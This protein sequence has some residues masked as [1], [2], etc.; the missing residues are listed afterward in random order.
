MRIISICDSTILAFS[1]AHP[2]Q[3]WAGFLA[4]PHAGHVHA[5]KGLAFAPEFRQNI[6]LNDNDSHYSENDSTSPFIEFLRN[7]QQ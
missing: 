6:N 2:Q 4:A 3:R 7:Q 5:Q 1:L